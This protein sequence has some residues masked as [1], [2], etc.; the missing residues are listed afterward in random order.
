MTTQGVTIWIGRYVLVPSGVW[1]RGRPGSGHPMLGVPAHPD[2]SPALP[3]FV[4]RDCRRAGVTRTHS[5]GRVIPEG[6]VWSQPA[7]DGV[8]VPQDIHPSQ[9]DIDPP[10]SPLPD[11][12][13][14]SC[15][16]HK[17]MTWAVLHRHRIRGG[18]L[19][20]RPPWLARWYRFPSDL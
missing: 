16:R 18:G 5:R 17:G 20:P 3:D 1:V 13:E 2:S 12:L 9:G 10:G 7:V 11:R 8:A 4:P 14:A 19:Q 6:P 15:T